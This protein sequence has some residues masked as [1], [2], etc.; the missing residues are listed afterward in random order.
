GYWNKPDASRAAFDACLDD[1][2]G[3]YLRTGDLGAVVKA[4]LFIVGRIKETIVHEGRTLYP[5]DIENVVEATA[6]S[7]IEAGAAVGVPGASTEDLAVVMEI[8]RHGFSL[9]TADRV[10]AAIAW[11][12][13]RAFEIVPAHL[14]FVKRGVIPRTSSGKKQ[15]LLCARLLTDGKLEIQAQWV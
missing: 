10:G 12:L 4:Q 1:G 14:V 2:S 11:E 13:Y 5:T 9:D 6:G 8:A 3:P 7:S 15:R